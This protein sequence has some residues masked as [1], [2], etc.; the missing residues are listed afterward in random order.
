MNKLLILFA[1][2]LF[3]FGCG[4]TAKT[5]EDVAIGFATA[6]DK[7]DFKGAKAFGTESTGK[8]LDMM[9]PMI[10]SMGDKLKEEMGKGKFEKATCEGTDDKKNC[11]VCCDKEGTEKE[12][13]LVKKDGKWLVDMNKEDMNKGQGAGEE[14]T[15][16]TTE[17]Q[18]EPAPAEHESGH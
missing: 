11:K 1:A 6:L 13:V 8:I 18:T 7:L 2:L 15:P 17:T 3:V 4:G 9:E 12:F 16:D 14:T 5:P 10:A